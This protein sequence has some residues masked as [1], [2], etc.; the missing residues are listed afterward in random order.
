M[1]KL[2]FVFR[3]LEIETDN[4]IFKVEYKKNEQKRNVL[5]LTTLY[6]HLFYS[7]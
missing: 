1:E 7:V 4:N 2:N 5:M 6:D 3:D